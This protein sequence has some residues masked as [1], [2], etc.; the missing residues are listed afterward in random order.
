MYEAVYVDY[1]FVTGTGDSGRPANNSGR[2]NASASASA[3]SSSSD[4]KTNG[5]KGK[6]KRGTTMYS[7]TMHVIIK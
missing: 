7:Y 6:T 4:G 2:M 5:D 3:A 1:D